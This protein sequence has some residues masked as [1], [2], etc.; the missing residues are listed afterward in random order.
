M[1]SFLHVK[2][3][4]FWICIAYIIDVNCFCLCSFCSLFHNKILLSFG[5][6]ILWDYMSLVTPHETRT[7]EY[8]PGLAKVLPSFWTLWLVQEYMWKTQ[9]R[10]NRISSTMQPEPIHEVK[11]KTEY[12][13][14]HLSPESD[15]DWNFSAP[16]L[17]DTWTSVLSFDK[18]SLSCVSVIY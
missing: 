16:R 8:D 13:H 2:H 9:A 6:P 17:L 1:K 5:E 11:N 3:L 14:S 10:L 7:M 15:W 4:S 12:S 18:A